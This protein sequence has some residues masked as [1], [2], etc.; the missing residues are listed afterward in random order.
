MLTPDGVPD[1]RML[2]GVG[3]PDDD[4]GSCLLDWLE[5]IVVDLSPRE[6]ALATAA[7]AAAPVVLCPDFDT[8]DS[9][10]DAR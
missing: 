10:P 3:S 8:P 4:I 9:V 6:A 5:G 2:Y 1:E 7:A